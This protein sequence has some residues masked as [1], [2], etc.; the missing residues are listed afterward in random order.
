MRYNI[1]VIIKKNKFESIIRLK[2][3]GKYRLAKEEL[4]KFINQYPDDMY[5]TSLY[6]NLLILEGNLNEALNLCMNN[7][8]SDSIKFQ[9]AIINKGLGNN[10]EAKKTFIEIYEKIHEPHILVELIFILVKEKKFY[11]AQQCMLRIDDDKLKSKD[12][13]KISIL[14]RTIYSQI[15][16][17]LKDIL[18]ED[19]NYGYYEQQVIDYDE[20]KARNFSINPDKYTFSSNIDKN[21]LFDEIK[22]LIKTADINEYNS[23]D[24]YIIHIPN[25]GTVNGEQVDYICVNTIMNTK[26][27]VGFI[28][29]HYY[30]KNAIEYCKDINSEKEYKYEN[31]ID[32]FNKKYGFN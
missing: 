18:K 32:K 15:F 27:I 31:R 14:K 1:D 13:F 20:K 10:E 28:P 26:N 5:A 19:K 9:Y 21:K 25:V 12:K 24:N 30:G 17:E 2:N 29:C 3:L 7:L 16:P 4:I 6:I 23:F 11:E 22:E 8:D